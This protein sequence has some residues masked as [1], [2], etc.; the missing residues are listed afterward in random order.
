VTLSGVT[1]L[2]KLFLL[3]ICGTLGF[4]GT[5]VENHWSTSSTQDLVQILT[6]RI[7]RNCKRSSKSISGNY[8][9]R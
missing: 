2:A 6:T 4:C 3:V 5:P 7:L 1:S 9:G 8:A